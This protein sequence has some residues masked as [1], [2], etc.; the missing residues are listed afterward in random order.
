MLY[1]KPCFPNNMLFSSNAS[2]VL[3]CYFRKRVLSHLNSNM[4]QAEFLNQDEDAEG[5]IFLIILSELF[6]Q[7]SRIPPTIKNISILTG[8]MHFLELK[9]SNNEARFLNSARMDKSTFYNLL[10][11]L[12]AFGQL[13]SSRKLLSR[14]SLMIF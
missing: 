2:F 5:F 4:L 7:L 1:I 10:F 14:E 3:S 8:R 12:T 9:E 13:N 6:H 11:E